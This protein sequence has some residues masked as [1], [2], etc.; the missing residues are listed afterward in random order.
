[1]ESNTV[2]FNSLFVAKLA[3]KQHWPDA[4]V[5]YGGEKQCACNFL[6]LISFAPVIP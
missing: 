6:F 4:L 1:M 5:R 3:G 2:T